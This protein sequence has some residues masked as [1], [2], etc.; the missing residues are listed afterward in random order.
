MDKFKIVLEIQ[1]E[2]IEGGLDALID[3]Q[4]YA[5]AYRAVLDR[6]GLFLHER[7]DGFEYRLTWQAIPSQ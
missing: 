7:G 3:C 5:E 6:S 1:A 4:E 2:S